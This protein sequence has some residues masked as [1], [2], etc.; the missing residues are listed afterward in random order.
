V[1]EL[2]REIIRFAHNRLC[3]AKVY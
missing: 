2:A 3:Q 1:T